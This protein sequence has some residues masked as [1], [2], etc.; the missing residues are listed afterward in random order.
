MMKASVVGVKDLSVLTA[1]GT[2]TLLHGLSFF[3]NHG[4]RVGLLGG[5]GAGKTLLASAMIGHFRDTKT[6]GNV[7][8][9]GIKVAKMDHAQLMSIRKQTVRM[10]L[11]DPL[12]ALNPTHT[13]GQHILESLRF[14]H[15]NASQSV[16][17][18]MAETL[19]LEVGFVDTGRT[20]GQ[21]PHQM[22]G[23]ECQRV[24]I[25]AALSCN[26]D[27]LI[28]DEPCSSLDPITSNHIM[29]LLKNLS[30]KHNMAL[31]VISHNIK[32]VCAFVDR[33]Y[34]MR[35]GHIID[36]LRSKD[37]GRRAQPYTQRLFDISQTKLRPK[38][39]SKAEPIMVAK[40][41]SVSY[42]TGTWMSRVRHTGIMDVSCK[43][44]PSSVLGICGLSGSGKTTLAYRLANLIA[45]PGTIELFGKEIK[46][47]MDHHDRRFFR[48][49]VQ[50]ILQSAA[51]SL[52][53]YKSVYD[54]LTEAARYYS[55]YDPLELRE[56]ALEVLGWVRLSS[57]VLKTDMGQ[58]SGGE[59]QRIALARTLLLRPKVL[60]L[61]EPTSALDFLAKDRILTI[62]EQ[63]RD[64]MRMAIVLISHDVLVMQR[65][66]NY[67]MFLDNGGVQEEGAAQR[68][69]SNPQ[70]DIVRDFL[71]NDTA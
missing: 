5:S 34:V 25:A 59:C 57:A 62:L 2:K 66:A 61:D 38:I 7:F 33:L 70:T 9:K 60:V 21:Y 8:I 53:P 24:C 30:K 56:K 18:D 31:F 52:N 3:I 26:P 41:L 16:L 36:S 12:S 10:I 63:L 32:Q 49:S 28:S 46:E 13:A 19:L 1:D 47:K 23:G 55:L 69:F 6:K 14:V 20:F 42:G 48:K 64:E 50:M 54:I 65:M 11:Q 45:G 4:E 68:F 27:L 58:L 67:V 43:V 37:L 39:S 71:K 44:Y 17:K 22:S 35:D 51:T 40:N 29:V 15:T